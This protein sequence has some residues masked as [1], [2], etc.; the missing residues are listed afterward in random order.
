VINDELLKAF[1]QFLTDES[2][3]CYEIITPNGTDNPV[4]RSLIEGKNLL[5]HIAYK[6]GDFDLKILEYRRKGCISLGKAQPAVAF[7]GAR[8]VFF[9]DTSGNYC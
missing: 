7:G 4:Q 8:V 2:E 1:V 9:F 5:N 6:V 3:I